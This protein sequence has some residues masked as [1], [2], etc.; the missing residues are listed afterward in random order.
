MSLL[1]T[2]ARLSL[3][4]VLLAALPFAAP[5]PAQAG[6]TGTITGSVTDIAGSPL[7]NVRVAAASPSGSYT[8]ATD[9]QGFISMQA[10]SPDT[11]A[12]SFQLEGYESVSVGGVTV[13]QDLVTRS[14]QILRRAQ[15][16][17]TIGEVSARTAGSL[18]KPYT[19]TDVY[20]VSGQQLAAATGDD[21]LHK[22]VF[23][24]LETVPGVTPIGGAYPAEPSIRGG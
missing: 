24:Y 3:L 7:A 12:I 4:S 23:Q 15:G 5:V 17:K 21:D 19:G 1:S 10:V 9:A 20:N 13:G 11:Y 22:T 16:L 18:F 8:A 2:R 14:N 6:T